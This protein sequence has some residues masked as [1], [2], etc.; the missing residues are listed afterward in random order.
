M[1]YQ[2]GG[3]DEVLRGGGCL[4]RHEIVVILRIRSCLIA[5][6]L[7]QCADSQLQLADASP[8]GIPFCYVFFV[9][10]LAH[11]FGGQQSQSKEIYKQICFTTLSS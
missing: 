1:S 3:V 5:T 7:R 2:L 10:C 6:D 4:L 9:L 8:E 11:L